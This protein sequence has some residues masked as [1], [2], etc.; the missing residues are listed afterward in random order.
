MPKKRV[1]P[2]GT[3]ERVPPVAPGLVIQAA[4]DPLNGGSPASSLN[5]RPELSAKL[6]DSLLE[7]FRASGERFCN[8]LG[9][10]A[11]PKGPFADS[12]IECST[13]FETNH[14]RGCM[15]LADHILRAMLRYVDEDGKGEK[16]C[17]LPGLSRGDTFYREIL[18]RL[19][20]K[21]LLDDVMCKELKQFLVDRAVVRQLDVYPPNTEALKKTAEKLLSTVLSFEKK[22]KERDII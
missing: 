10:V 20:Q 2:K 19:S 6:R 12:V 11:D 9:I 7:R 16:R 8:M 1:V 17:E 15:A 5:N 21:K 13:L 4:A 18:K 3:I 14:Y 22:I